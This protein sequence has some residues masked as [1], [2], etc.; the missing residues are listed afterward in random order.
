MHKSLCFV[1]F[2]FTL[3]NAF[4]ALQLSD[5]ERQKVQDAFYNDQE[6]KLTPKQRAGLKHRVAISDN[7]KRWKNGT[8]PYEIDSSLPNEAI[9]LIRQAAEH[10]RSKTGNCIKFVP[11][12]GQ[13]E[14]IKM[15]RGN[16]CWSYLGMTGWYP[17]QLSLGQY[18]W[19]IGTVIHELLHAVGFDHEQNRPDR[20]N[21]LEIYRQNILSGQEHNFDKTPGGQTYNDFDFNSIMLYGEYAFSRQRDVLP[22]MRD[23]SRQHKL[24]EPYDKQEMTVFDVYQIKRFYNCN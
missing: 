12:N 2:I 15:F 13:K 23:R 14:Y 8:I 20:D 18:C 6:L 21:Y 3:R 4:G 16:G 7:T 11:R 5:D 22:T 17:Q 19:Y 24:T 10:I 9:Q 1:V